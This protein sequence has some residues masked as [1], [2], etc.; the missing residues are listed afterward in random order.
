MFLSI[1]LNDNHD[2]D[3]APY[4]YFIF[5][6][7]VWLLLVIGIIGKIVDD[8]IY[9]FLLLCSKYFPDFL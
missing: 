9:L 8:F 5:K 3:D 4:K 1:H 7:Y 2:N 6:Q